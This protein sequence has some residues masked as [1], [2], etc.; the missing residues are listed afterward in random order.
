MGSAQCA[1]AKTNALPTYYA[2][3]GNSNMHI[4][5]RVY[6]RHPVYSRYVL[7]CTKTAFRSNEVCKARFRVH[8]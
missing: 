8:S 5:K 4:V 2:L 1:S 7:E 3:K 6:P